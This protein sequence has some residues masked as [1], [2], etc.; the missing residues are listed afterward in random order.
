LNSRRRVRWRQRICLRGWAL[1][2]RHR[3]RRPT[4]RAGRPSF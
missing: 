4:W 2:H 1:A 3:R